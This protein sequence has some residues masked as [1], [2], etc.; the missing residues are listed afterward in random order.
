[1]VRK[2]AI[3]DG[4]LAWQ[5]RIAERA[6]FNSQQMSDGLLFFLLC[7]DGADWL[8]CHV[9]RK[10]PQLTAPIGS[11]LFMSQHMV[12]ATRA[13]LAVG[14]VRFLNEGVPV[15]NFNWNLLLEWLYTRCG[16]QT[17]KHSY[18]AGSTSRHP[19]RSETIPAI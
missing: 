7:M 8:P 15:E 1:M 10:L 14:G 18:S 9:L 11:C 12:E 4:V 5:Q 2:V 16:S 17:A 3:F 6:A 19:P 13:Y